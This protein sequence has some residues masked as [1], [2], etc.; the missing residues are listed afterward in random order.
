MRY[1]VR[2]WGGFVKEL[3]DAVRLVGSPTG[4]P[5]YV[6]DLTDTELVALSETHDV[7]LTR[8]GDDRVLYLDE[9]GGRFRTR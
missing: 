7:M 2:M 3:P 6:V 9:K 1:Q 5:Q 4:S 8:R